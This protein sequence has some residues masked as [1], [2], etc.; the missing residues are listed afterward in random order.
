VANGTSSTFNSTVL[1]ELSYS[2][3]TLSEVAD[4]SLSSAN[5]GS[6]NAEL[7]TGSGEDLILSYTPTPEP[8]S[9][10]LGGLAISP[11]MLARRRRRLA[12][13]CDA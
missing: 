5:N 8:T 13:V 4:S 12:L 9:F 7:D 6:S 1:G 3:F 2:G 10:L 11:L